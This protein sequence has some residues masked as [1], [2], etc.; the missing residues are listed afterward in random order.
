MARKTLPAH[1]TRDR[2]RDESVLL[3]S[4]ESL[5]RMIGSLQRQLDVATG[6]LTPGKPNGSGRKSVAAAR[7]NAKAANSRTT[8]T[9]AAVRRKSS[10]RKSTKKR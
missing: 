8:G 4:A 1:P 6:R 2:T 9:R 3:R 7:S 10:A 5:G